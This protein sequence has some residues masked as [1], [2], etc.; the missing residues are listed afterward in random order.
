MNLTSIVTYA[1]GIQA[2][3]LG[4]V[5]YI[6]FWYSSW[7]FRLDRLH[8]VSE[9]KM[10]PYTRLFAYV[11]GIRELGPWPRL[12]AYVFSIRTGTLGLVVR[13]C[14]WYTSHDFGLSHVH[15]FVA[16][17]LG[18]WAYFEAIA[19]PDFKLNRDIVFQYM[20]RTDTNFGETLTCNVMIV[21]Y[22]I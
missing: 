8:I 11:F 14:F 22:C 10:G 1:F 17:E 20:I 13:I 9:F 3:T 7:D 12:F 16:Y 18:L 5:V 21:Y 19:S 6:R 2:G 4:L 15:T